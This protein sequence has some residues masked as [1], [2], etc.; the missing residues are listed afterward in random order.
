MNF[1]NSSGNIYGTYSNILL[2]NVNSGNTF[3]ASTLDLKLDG[4]TI[5]NTN[6]T[7]HFRSG[8]DIMGEY[9][10]IKI[11][12]TSAEIFRAINSA[13]PTLVENLEIDNV[14]SLVFAEMS[15]DGTYR[16]LIVGSSSVKVFCSAS[17]TVNGT[18]SNVRIDA[19]DL[20]FQS[21]SQDVNIDNMTVGHCSSFF[22]NPTSTT[23]VNKLDMVGNFL[24]F[25]STNLKYYG[26]LTNSRIDMRESGDY[27]WFSSGSLVE[28]CK[29]LSNNVSYSLIADSNYLVFTMTNQNQ[30]A[31]GFTY[32]NIIDADI[33]S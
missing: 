27:I 26:L 14:G 10:N 32:G 22:S 8:V 6:N 7:S 3:Y 31:S 19:A 28:R 30:S 33:V 20:L 13:I 21:T 1:L 11:K 15:V 12:G 25:S 5:L 16:N 23:K 4:F 17:S 2:E 9:R 29:I 18:F 24:G